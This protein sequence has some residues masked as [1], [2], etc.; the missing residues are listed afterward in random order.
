MDPR[1]YFLHTSHILPKYSPY[2]YPTWALLKKKNL[3]YHKYYPLHPTYYPTWVFTKILITMLPKLGHKLNYLHKKA[4]THL[5]C[6][7]NSKSPTKLSYKAR[8]YTEL[9]KL[10]A[11]RHPKARCYTASLKTHCYMTHLKARCY[12]A[13]LKARCYMAIFLQNLKKPKYYFGTYLQSSNI[14]L[15][16]IYKAK[17]LFCHIFTKPEYYFG[18]NNYI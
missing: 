5:S 16:H 11:T 3:G 6:G 10:V 9:L 13:P 8:C 17:I 15:A 2:Y 1:K 12:T 14:I 7:Q 4:Q 18:K